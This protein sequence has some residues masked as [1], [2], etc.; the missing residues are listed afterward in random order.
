MSALTRNNVTVTGA[1]QKT[2]VQAAPGS[3]AARRSR[4]VSVL[5]G[6]ESCSSSAREALYLPHH[7]GGPQP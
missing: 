6:L 5:A 7:R 3:T 1:A 4:A 2:V